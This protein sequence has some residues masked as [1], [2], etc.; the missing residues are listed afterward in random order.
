MYCKIVESFIFS[1]LAESAQTLI[2]NVNYEVPSLKKLSSKYEQQ[3]SET[4]RAIETCKRQS[5]TYQNEFNSNS[6]KLGIEGTNIK[7][8]LNAQLDILPAKMN[9][10]FEQLPALIPVCDYYKTFVQ[11]IC[12]Q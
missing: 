10:L 1:C 9:E 6:K 11:F 3:I 8:E 2:R 12:Q 4:E 5:K 7:E